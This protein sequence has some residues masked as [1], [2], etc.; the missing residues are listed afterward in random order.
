V[1]RCKEVAGIAPGPAP[2]PGGPQFGAPPSPDHSLTYRRPPR[3][4][5]QRRHG[6][7]TQAVQPTG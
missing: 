3:C 5:Q 2:T 4:R 6:C 1:R 7:P